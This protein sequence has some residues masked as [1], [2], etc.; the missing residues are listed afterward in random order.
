MDMQLL[1]TSLDVK[2]MH[3]DHPYTYKIISEMPSEELLGCWVNL[4]DDGKGPHEW[5]GLMRFYRD[6]F[7]GARGAYS[8][9]GYLWLRMKP[10][11]E[12]WKAWGFSVEPT[13]ELKSLKHAPG[14][15]LEWEV[16]ISADTADEVLGE[17]ANQI[18]LAKFSAARA[19]TLLQNDARRRQFGSLGAN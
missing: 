6:H 7:M 3:K 19:I 12:L 13:Y 10:L 5:L 4:R 2:Q 9:H 17:I 15:G 14:L 8:V 1:E 11:K 18:S 16:I